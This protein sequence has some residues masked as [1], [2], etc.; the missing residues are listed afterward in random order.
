[1][2]VKTNTNSCLASTTKD[3]EAT[4][5]TIDFSQSI[6]KPYKHEENVVI[7]KERFVCLDEN[8]QKI[9]KQQ[10]KLSQVFISVFKNNFS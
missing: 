2:Y 1:M 8:T 5:I 7:H 10:D 4:N 9:S 3:N 6:T